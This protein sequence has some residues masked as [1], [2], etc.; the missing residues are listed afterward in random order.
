MT[1]PFGNTMPLPKF[2]CSTRKH[3][4]SDNTIDTKEAL[5]LRN[6]ERQQFEKSQRVS[7][8]DEENRQ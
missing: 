4:Y 8:L 6:M 5:Q 1:S 2:Y 3:H 7:I